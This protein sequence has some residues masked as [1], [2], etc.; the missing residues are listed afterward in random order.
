MVF[1]RLV[2]ITAIALSYNGKLIWQVHVYSDIPNETFLRNIGETQKNGYS[3]SWN[4][5]VS[6][7]RCYQ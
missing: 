3:I 5:F 2:C 4:I 7:D 1:R 6:Q